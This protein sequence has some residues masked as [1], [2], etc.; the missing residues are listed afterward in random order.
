MGGLYGGK[1][2][3]VEGTQLEKLGRGG[4]PPVIVEGWLNVVGT[5]DGVYVETGWLDSD[6]ITF[7]L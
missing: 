1:G 4:R 2:L 6:V 3:V 7:W 5:Y